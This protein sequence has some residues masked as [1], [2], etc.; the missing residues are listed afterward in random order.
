[1]CLRDHVKFDL[2]KARVNFK[3]LDV[4]PR[5]N[6]IIPYLFS[7]QCFQAP[8]S[9]I[10]WQGVLNA[11]TNPP[12]CIQQNYLFS[13]NP[14]VEGSEDCLYLNVYTPK[15]RSFSVVKQVYFWIG[16]FQRSLSP[17]SH[18]KDLP[19]MVFIHY[20]AFFAGSSSSDLLG[21]EY[22]MDED[23]ILVTFNYRLGVLGKFTLSY[24]NKTVCQ[25]WAQQRLF[26]I[27]WI[28]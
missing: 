12:Q 20:G 6:R 15:V 22:F 8:V 11:T 28:A 13:H 10:R 2:C 4:T 25:A 23:V 24:W 17:R 21:P 3:V 7:L 18:G 1:M 19:V 14:E 26:K 27:V 16:D 5:L 9:P